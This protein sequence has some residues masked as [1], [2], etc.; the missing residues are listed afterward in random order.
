M[1]TTQ[2]LNAPSVETPEQVQTVSIRITTQL[3]DVDARVNRAPGDVIEKPAQAAMHWVQTGVAQLVKTQKK[4]ETAVVN[5]VLKPETAEASA[6][7][8]EE[9]ADVSAEIADSQ[10]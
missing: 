6:V 7:S 10:S 4:K 3:Y 9:T 2:N 5:A 8:G 1:A